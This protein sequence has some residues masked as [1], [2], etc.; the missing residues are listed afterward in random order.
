M[1]KYFSILS[2]TFAIIALAGCMPIEQTT[3]TE[4][5]QFNKFTDEVL[6]LSFDY[7]ATWGNASWNDTNIIVFSG[8][9]DITMALTYISPDDDQ[10]NS[11]KEICLA[12]WSKSGHND[13]QQEN[14][15]D[16]FVED[17]SFSI[18][19]CDAEIP[20]LNSVTVAD[21][22]HTDWTPLEEEIE[23]TSTLNLGRFYYF[24]L[25]SPYFTS[26]TVDVTA[27][28]IE[29]DGVCLMRIASECDTEVTEEIVSESDEEAVATV[30]D[31]PS[32]DCPLSQNLQ[33]INYEERQ[34]ALDALGDFNDSDLGI[35][36]DDMLSS[37]TIAPVDESTAEAILTEK[38]NA[39]YAE[40][41]EYSN[42][43]MGI[44]FTYPVAF[45]KMEANEDNTLI[46]AEMFSVEV[47]TLADAIAEEADF[48]AT[49]DEGPVCIGRLLTE[50]IW[51]SNYDTFYNSDYSDDGNILQFGSN[52]FLVG[53]D[54]H[55]GDPLTESKYI[56]F[57]GDN[58]FEIRG[59]FFKNVDQ[60]TW[61]TPY[62]AINYKLRTALIN[63]IVES[64]KFY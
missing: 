38:Y 42:D 40:R 14:G 13:M 61:M 30:P 17:G 16:V 21:Y 28:S 32:V 23:G 8:Q 1:R 22:K 25:Q 2:F 29:T 19:D 39:D 5:P 26:L 20:Y 36:V 46:N 62:E 7:P 56:T 53:H 48:Y 45:G 58:R 3:Q 6:G 43:E 51:Q 37:L 31:E 49:N 11:A 44:S 57:V 55:C 24:D 12:R 59:N 63:S 52:K 9:P 50:Q 33:C 35:E 4:T 54:G 41:A 10:G 34:I 47:T 27:P 18:G 60:F 15:E 64:M